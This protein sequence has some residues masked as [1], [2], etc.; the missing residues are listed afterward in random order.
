MTSPSI[1]VA[2][3]F[4]AEPIREPL[5]YWIDRFAMKFNI[6]FAPYDQVFQQ[7]LDPTSPLARNAS[8]I[9]LLLLKLDDWLEAGPG[10]ASGAD[11][12]RLE[13]NVAD[14]IAAVESLVSRAPVPCILA[15]CPASPEALE[16]A[17]LATMLARAEGLVAGA[18]AATPAVHVITPAQVEQL[19]PVGDYYDP[20][21]A[22]EG[23]IPYTEDYF[24]ALATMLAR[25]IRTLVNAPYK[26]IVVDCDNTLWRGVVGEVGPLGVELDAPTRAFHEF[27]LQQRAAGM[28]LVL[29]SKNAESAVA[30]TFESRPDFPLRMEHITGKRINW[31][32]KSANIHSLAREL[33]LSLDSFVFIDDSPYE[34]AEVRAHC[35]DVLAL[36]FPADSTDVSRLMTHCWAFDKGPVTRED[37]A[38][39]ATY[40]A[41]AARREAFERAGSLDD[42]LRTLDLAVEIAVPTATDLPRAAQMTQRTNQFNTTTIRRTDGE[43]SSAGSLQYRIVKVRD[44]FGDYG[45][46]GLMVFDLTGGTLRVE[47]L[48][49][50]CRALGRRVEHHMLAE[51]GRI[52]GE[53]GLP[54][55]AIQFVPSPRNAPALAFLKSLGTEPTVADGYH[56][57]EIPQALALDAITIPLATSLEALADDAPRATTTEVFR[58]GT[59]DLMVAILADLTTTSGIRNAIEAANQRARPTTAPSLVPPRTPGEHQIAAIWRAVLRL[60]AVGVHDNFFDLGGTS[61]AAVPLFARLSKVVGARLDPHLLFQAPTIEQLASAVDRLVSSPAPSDDGP[62]SLV[63]IQPDGSRPPLF[64]IHAGAGSILFYYPLATTLGPDQPVYG[65]R[66]RG[67]DGRSAADASVEAMASHYLAEVRTIQPQG[68]YHLG[69]FCFGATIAFEMAQQLERA[70]ESVALLCSLDGVAPQFHDPAGRSP[71]GQKFVPKRETLPSWTRP[72]PTEFARG[73]LYHLDTLRTLSWRQRASYLPNKAA[74]YVTRLSQRWL[75]RSLRWHTARS[76]QAVPKAF[77]KFRWYFTVNNL[78]ARTRY[79]PTRYP[80]DI[81]VVTLKGRYREPGLG[82]S[83]WIA[84]RVMSVEIAATF[85]FHRDLL[86]RHAVGAVGAALTE[87]I[88]VAQRPNAPNLRSSPTPESTAASWTRP[89]R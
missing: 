26:V 41:N 2:A 24:V 81:A 12:A 10:T 23:A 48:L 74:G 33:N 42:F 87:L 13:R 88:T 60:D 82:W 58:R 76:G 4:T 51:L 29:C 77:R 8:G 61:I 44:R 21:A 3:N 80:G 27:L 17:L 1:I 79:A 52:A 43:V 40:G 46:V 50:S 11:N 68:P 32:A 39:A 35:P 85:R 69:G 47:A 53:A 70:G 45:T 54:T 9:N 63:A 59:N 34:V 19:Y 83:R 49:L 22:A 86:A 84:G 36:Q 66:A 6:Q 20:A 38:R 28:L 89:L 75:I 30:E 62:P 14:L 15:L 5:V 18:F 31:E 67:I 72:L 65:L 56:V 64:L 71:G 16:D 25:R 7:L 78:L 73:V 37:R 55:I 57:F